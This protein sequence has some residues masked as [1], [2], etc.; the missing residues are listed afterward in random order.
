MGE[1]RTDFRTGIK[2]FFIVPELSIFPEDY[3]KAFCLHGY[4]SY[5]IH[6]DPYCP[7]VSKIHL[8][9]SAFP[10][11]VLFFNIDRKIQ[12]LDWSALI[13]KLQYTYRGR[14]K[15]GVMYQKLNNPEEAHRLEHLY[16]YDIGISC[17]C[18]PMEYQKAKNL[19]LFL[20]VMMTNQVKGQ[21]NHLRA[22]CNDSFKISMLFK[23]RP[24]RCAMRD[25]SISHF[26]CVFSEDPPEIPMHEKIR[27]IQMSLRGSL[28][29]V[30]AVLCLKR[31][32]GEDQIHVFVFR[33]CE[34]KDGLDYEQQ[35]KV[36]NVVYNSYQNN[37][38][39]FLR[40]LFDAERIRI[41]VNRG[42]EAEHEPAL[43]YDQLTLDVD[44]LL[45][46]VN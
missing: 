40:Q 15:I 5:F 21:R 18:I 23:G 4:E 41:A 22:L 44:K 27:G 25:I 37:V 30:D 12:G 34:D 24:Y 11:I 13:R 7:L 6:D 8:L 19:A 28:C 17:G 35:E 10:E 29:N 14:A 33:T 42:R 3:L 9:I 38:G 39:T 31:V 2:T 20:H 45:E 46:S 43:G 16:L 32:L 36:N 1:E 26:S